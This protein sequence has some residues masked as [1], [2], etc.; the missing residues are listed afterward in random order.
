ME[1]LSSQQPVINLNK[2]ILCSSVE[3]GNCFILLDSPFRFGLLNH[4]S[5]IY[6]DFQITYH[7]PFLVGYYNQKLIFFCFHFSES[8][9]TVLKPLTMSQLDEMARW[10]KYSLP[11]LFFY[12]MFWNLTSL[13]LH[14]WLCQLPGGEENWVNY[15]CRNT[16]KILLNC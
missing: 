7:Q 8:G 5:F 10:S 3:V 11:T 9:I 16:M 4:F 2:H 6:F 12:C 14:I 1:F 15:I 13:Y